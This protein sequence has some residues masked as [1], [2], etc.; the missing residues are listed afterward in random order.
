MESG[1]DWGNLHG[2]FVVVSLYCG[3][4]NRAEQETCAVEWNAPKE[5][6]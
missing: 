3:R 6:N 4:W 2:V 5:S 1:F